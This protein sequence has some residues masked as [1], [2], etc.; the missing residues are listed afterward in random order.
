MTTLLIFI[1]IC[2][3]LTQILLYSSLFGWLRALVPGSLFKCAL[4][5]G[6]HVGYVTLFLMTFSGVIIIAPTLIDYFLA[7]LL[8]AGTSYILNKIVGDKGINLSNYQ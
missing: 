8:S 7:G 5:L 1:L 6:F 4:C 3:G 2:Y